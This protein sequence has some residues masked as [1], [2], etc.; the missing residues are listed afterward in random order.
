[1]LYF[2]ASIF[3]K[4]LLINTLRKT[5]QV[6]QER[7]TFVR[8]K[9]LI[10]IALM[11]TVA[12]TARG[13]KLI[14][15]ITTHGGSEYLSDVA[16]IVCPGGSYYW[17]S[18][19][20][21]GS[22]VATKLNEA[23]FDAFVLHYRHAGTRYFLFGPLTPIRSHHYP[24][25]LEDVT[26]AIKELKS[27][28]YKKVAL[29]GFSAGGH[30]VLLAGETLAGKSE[31]AGSDSRKAGDI[32]EID[33]IAAVY[34]VVTFTEDEIMHKRSR[35]AFLGGKRRNAELRDALSLEKHVPANMPPVLLVNCKD[36]PTV[37]WRNSER[38]DAALSAAGIPHKWLHY[39]QGG[40][41]FGASAEK[42]PHESARWID[43][44]VEMLKNL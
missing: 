12:L 35:N 34:P 16:V 37:D 30:L 8:V 7:I 14:P 26:A 39:E 43:T 17:L 36:D 31:V 4:M 22:E 13:Q 28:G 24:E 10:I 5:L 27:K 23:G 44:F 32:P 40:H 2:G 41:G 9:K 38:M 25:A 15:H 42:N 18:K 3:S 1:M 21:E 33:L 19:K 29:A 6:S 20:W 11:M